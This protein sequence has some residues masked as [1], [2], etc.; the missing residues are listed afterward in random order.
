MS[1]FPTA[2]RQMQHNNE[3]PVDNMAAS[4]VDINKLLLSTMEIESEYCN[5]FK[6]GNENQTKHKIPMVW[7]TQPFACERNQQSEP[8]IYH[9]EPNALSKVSPITHETE[10]VAHRA[11]TGVAVAVAS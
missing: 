2:Q 9:K 7:A 5:N 10:S 11:F 8:K 6:S 3:M 4:R 1:H